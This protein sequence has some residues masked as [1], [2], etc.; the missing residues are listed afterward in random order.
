MIVHMNII[1]MGQTIMV[2]CRQAVIK[3]MIRAI[4]GSV[5]L[6]G[7]K[8]QIYNAALNHR[9]LIAPSLDTRLFS[10]VRSEDIYFPCVH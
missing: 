8:L 3:R 6:K 7:G 9:V 1:G 10:T 5:H 4:Y 2:R